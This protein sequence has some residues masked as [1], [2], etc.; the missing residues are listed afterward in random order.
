MRSRAIV[1]GLSASLAVSVVSGQSPPQQAP[2]PTFKAEVEYVEVD[3]LVVDKDGNFVRNLTKED[4]RIFEDGK[5]QKISAFT[6][7]DIRNESVGP[8]EPASGSVDSDVQSNE[9]VVRRPRLRRGPR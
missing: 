2:T 5:P 9:R 1:A 7:V 3:T 6:L 8:M 4:F